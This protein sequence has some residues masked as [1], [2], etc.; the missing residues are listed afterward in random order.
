VNEITPEEQD[1]L[2]ALLAKH[3]ER[4]LKLP[5][6]RE[7]DVGFEFSEGKPTGRLAIRVHVNKK[8]PEA[9]LTEAQKIPDELEGVPVDVIQSNPELQVNRNANQNPVIGGVNIGSTQGG[10][11]GTLTSIVFD[12]GDLRPMALSCYHV[13]VFEPPTTDEIVA[14]PRTSNAADRLGPLARWDKDL[15]C[16]VCWVT[17]RNVSTGLADLPNGARGTKN[18]VIGMKVIKSGRMTAITRG[19]IDGVTLGKE[20]T[21]VPDADFPPATGEISIP[22]DSGSLWME[23][24]S[25]MAVGLHYAGETSMNASDERAWAKWITAVTEKLNIFFLDRAAISAAFIGS[26]CTVLARTRPNAPCTLRVVYPSG[27]RSSAKGLGAATADAQGFV[28]WRW[29][30]GTHTAR[31]GAGTGNPFGLPVVGFVSLDGGPEFTVEASLQGTT[32]TT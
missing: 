3:Q 10:G 2:L 21:V 28:R 32:L 26:G 1:R 12:R 13:I 9:E 11:A 20:F 30:I 15:D 6:V 16:A 22:G 29:R 27:R 19:V 8:V 5:N 18:A 23:A 31:K 7:V 4:L 25:S 24:S 17:S 14:Q